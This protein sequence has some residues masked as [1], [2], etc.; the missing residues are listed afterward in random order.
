MDEPRRPGG[1]VNPLSAPA[2]LAPSEVVAQ[3]IKRMIYPNTFERVVHVVRDLLA[4]L[5]LLLVSVLMVLMLTFLAAI[6]HRVG[7]VGDS[8]DPGPAPTA[9]GCPF[10]PDDCGGVMR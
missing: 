6:E 8:V 10:G 3:P 7:Q 1:P 9:T 4:C 5:A 2:V